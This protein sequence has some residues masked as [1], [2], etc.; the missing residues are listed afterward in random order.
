MPPLFAQPGMDREFH[1]RAQMSARLL[2]QSW[3]EPRS[4]RSP[5]GLRASPS[6]RCPSLSAKAASIA[7]RHSWPFDRSLMPSRACLHQPVGGNFGEIAVFSSEQGLLSFFPVAGRI[8]TA[9]QRR[10]GDSEAVACLF[11]RD[12]RVYAQAQT[13]GLPGKPISE[14]PVATTVRPYLKRQPIAV[15]DVVDAL[16]R[17]DRAQR[18]ACQ[19]PQFLAVL[20]ARVQV[21]AEATDLHTALVTERAS[22]W[23]TGSPSQKQKTHAFAR[24]FVHF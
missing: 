4:W 7:Q 9:P 5:Y 12:F 8:S 23:E 10:P 21:S 2:R 6:W 24:V 1:D 15:C 13:L 3:R 18:L 17:L 22:C 11:Q 19:F 14:A 16:L 20:G